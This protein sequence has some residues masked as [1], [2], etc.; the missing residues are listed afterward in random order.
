MN[1]GASTL[2]KGPLCNSGFLPIF[3]YIEDFSEEK[4]YETVKSIL[5]LIGTITEGPSPFFEAGSV[6]HEKCPSELQLK[7]GIHKVARDDVR[8]L[9]CPLSGFCRHLK[10]ITRLFSV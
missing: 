1:S 5:S 10:T 2:W 7:A 6:T 4:M 8:L 9:L 3:W